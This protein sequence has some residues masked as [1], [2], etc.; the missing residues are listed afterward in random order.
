MRRGVSIPS[1]RPESTVTPLP[2]SWP[3]KPRRLLAAGRRRL[4]RPDDRDG[5]LVLELKLASDEEEGRPVVHQ[6]A[7]SSEI[8]SSRRE[9]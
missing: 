6:A 2:T 9:Q 7:G 4:P 3:G 5:A 8:V 1:A